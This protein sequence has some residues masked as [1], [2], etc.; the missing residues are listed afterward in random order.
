[1]LNSLRFFFPVRHSNVVSVISNTST[2]QPPRM[3]LSKSPSVMTVGFSKTFR[4]NG[5]TDD[6]SGCLG[7]GYPGL[8]RIPCE[9]LSSWLATNTR[10]QGHTIKTYDHFFLVC[11]VPVRSALTRKPVQM[12][13]WNRCHYM[14]NPRGTLGGMFFYQLLHTDASSGPWSITILS[15]HIR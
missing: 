5:L 7:L 1:L 11:R 14:R 2:L 13:M 4:P 6:V 9:R 3:N 8:S 15:A 12:L 10:T